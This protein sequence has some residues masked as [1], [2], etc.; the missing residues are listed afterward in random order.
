MF[1]LLSDFELASPGLGVLQ[2][3]SYALVPAL[4]L[5]LSYI[6]CI[7]VHFTSVVSLSVE[8]K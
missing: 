1:S 3:I 5:L 7:A 8:D 4:V 2:A 6:T